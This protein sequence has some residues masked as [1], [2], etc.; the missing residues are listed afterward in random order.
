M[1]RTYVV[2]ISGTTDN[3]FFTNYAY[4]L[5]SEGKFKIDIK[6]SL[7]VRELDDDE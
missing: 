4:F 7:I 6:D 5:R 1:N 3:C 2:P